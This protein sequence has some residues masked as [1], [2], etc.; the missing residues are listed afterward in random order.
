MRSSQVLSI[1]FGWAIIALVALLVVLA[2]S[3][4]QDLIRGWLVSFA[5][6]SAFPLASL[7]L[8]M[9]HALTGGAWGNVLRPV[10]RLGAALVP[11]M[12]LAFIPIA[13]ALPAIY[14]W[15]SNAPNVY[16]SVPTFLIRAAVAL[17]GWSILG[18][19]FAFVRPGRL[20][21][22]LGLAFHCFVMTSIA[23]DWFLSTEPTYVSTAFPA[24]VVIKQL[25]VALAAATV[26]AP[27]PRDPYTNSQL[28]R[29]FIAT[30]LGV[31]YLELMTYIV[32][33]YGDL[34]EKAAWFLKRS[35][36]PWPFVL[37]G[38]LLTAFGAFA[39]LLFERLRRSGGALTVIGTLLLA[40]FLLDTIWLTAPGLGHTS[41][42][43]L[44]AGASLAVL[45]LATWFAARLLSPLLPREGIAFAGENERESRQPTEIELPSG[46]IARREQPQ[47][48]S[49]RSSAEPTEAPAED[50]SQAP[51]AADVA[52][53]PVLIITFGFLAF[54]VVAGAGLYAYSKEELP[55]PRIPSERSFPRPTLEANGA[56]ALSKLEKEQRASL[57]S[58]GWVDR[59][60]GIIRVPIER[61][62]AAVVARGAHAL[63]PVESGGPK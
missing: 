62:M 49:E 2:S 23:T 18:L 29:F 22:G 28:G 4:P 33:W 54:V 12:A 61:A 21:A 43:L 34:P 36:G 5:A 26:F 45:S 50:V 13:S 47:A 25:L 53:R 20:I 59:Q 24:T 57:S 9:I 30:V 39:A 56:T 38:A 1:T 17:T 7:V 15:A 44:G 51:E 35:S 14:P 8:L 19:A 16:L 11:V 6:W 63:D 31:F 58:Y 40:A 48:G 42:V 41:R 3:S 46:P 60:S 32:Q 10:F 52:V 55:R 27:A 37:G